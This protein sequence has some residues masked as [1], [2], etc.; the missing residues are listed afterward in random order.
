MPFS[1]EK[2]CIPPGPEHSMFSFDWIFMKV[3]DNL[4]RHNISD[5]FESGKITLELL[6]L[7]CKKQNKNIFHFVQSVACV[8]FWFDPIFMKLADK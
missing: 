1:A 8:I 7:E 5:K 2:P 4:D 6:A 3:A